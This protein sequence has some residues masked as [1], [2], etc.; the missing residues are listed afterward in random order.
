[1]LERMPRPG[2]KLLA[3]GSGMCNASNACPPEAFFKRYGRNG[4]F[5]R[6]AFKH[7]GPEALAEFLE[8]RGLPLVEAEGGKLFPIT[9]S[10]RDLLDLLLRECAV[11]GVELRISATARAAHRAAEG[12]ALTLAGGET[13]AA[14]AL[15][16]A[17]GGKSYPA[18]GSDGSCFALADSLG[19]RVIA[20]RPA[21]SPVIA[22]AWAFSGLSGIALEGR[23]LR[24]MRGTAIAA[25]GR[26]DVL[27]THKGLSGPGI[28]D[29]S[30]D[31]RPGDAIELRLLEEGASADALVLKALKAG[32]AK[33]LGNALKPLPLP[34]RVMEALLAWLGI[35]AGMK[36]ARF[37]KAERA[38][39]CLALEGLRVGVKALGGWDDAM[40]TAG[41]VD[42]AEVDPRSMESRIVPRLYF[43]GEVMDI[44]GDTG[45][46]NIQAAISTGALAG[47]SAARAALATSGASAPRSG[48]GGSS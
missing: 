18:L 37:P 24:V 2:L 41:G 44:D 25:K 28:L 22:E 38:R 47:A 32:G 5:L 20:P 42:L 31:I 6:Y 15:C 8:S 46:F 21:L 11:A 33:N 48:R 1:M 23:S 30:R 7:F 14:R 13:V 9:K 39:L 35:D 34:E 17:G 4:S 10:A 45:G 29:L 36:A 3:S 26:G 43:A 27:F 16:L 19:H 40:A 12:F